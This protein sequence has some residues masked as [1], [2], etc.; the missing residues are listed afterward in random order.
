MRIIISNDTKE[1]ILQYA[2]PI[3]DQIEDED[4]SKWLF[5]GYKVIICL[6]QKNVI[7]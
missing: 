5:A 4:P 3:L 1:T 2:K 6:A 7:N